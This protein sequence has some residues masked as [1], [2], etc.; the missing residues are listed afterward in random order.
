MLSRRPLACLALVLLATW[1]CRPVQ[2][3]MTDAAWRKTAATAKKLMGKRGRVNEKLPLLRALAKEDTRRAAE[4]VFTWHRTSRTLVAEHIAPEVTKRRADAVRYEARIA[5]KHHGDIEEASDLERS[6]LAKR[7]DALTAAEADAEIEA[8]VQT[9]LAKTVDALTEAEALVWL[10]Q[11]GVPALLADRSE[12]PLLDACL[13]RLLQGPPSAVAPTILAILQRHL[14]PPAHLAALLWVGRHKPKN[15][16]LRLGPSLAAS[17]PAVRRATIRVLGLLDDVRSV[18]LLIE[19]LTSASGLPAEE[20]EILLQRFTGK[21]FS[22][23][24]DAWKQW[25][26]AEGEAW[27]GALDAAKRFDPLTMSGGVSF[28]GLRSPSKRVAFVLDRSGSMKAPAVHF[29]QAA[30]TTG[31]DKESWAGKTRLEV[32]KIQLAR[33]INNLASDVL[34][35]LIFY[36]YKVKGLAG[37]SDA[38]RGLAQ[39]QGGSAEVV[40]VARA[41]LVHK[42]VRRPDEGAR[43]RRAPDAEGTARGSP[44]AGHRHDLPA[45]GRRTDA[46]PRQGPQDACGCRSGLSGVQACEWRAPHRG[47]C[48]RGGSGPQ[49]DLD[50]EDRARERREVRRR[51]HGLTCGGVSGPR[52]VRARGGRPARGCPDA[53]RRPVASYGSR[54]R[55]RA[56]TPR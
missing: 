10:S 3:R 53:G 44:E 35:T 30:P 1:T 43:V 36:D 8:R 27:L 23:D 48:H 6:R 9:A 39:E 21:T 41:G 26:A 49:R 7:R 55:H 34:F 5:K 25:W 50:E 28:Y 40:H 38:R 29:T 15:A 22:A 18:P 16:A 31:G 54:S 14:A 52:P 33:T 12:G 19:G 46:L 45:L 42:P 32:A 17:S 56:A 20:I 24:H 47:A 37:A 11:R 2:A 13:G 4:L 51:R